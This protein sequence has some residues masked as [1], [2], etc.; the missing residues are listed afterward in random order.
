MNL[1]T[2]GQKRRV[3]PIVRA[4]IGSSSNRLPLRVIPHRHVAAKTGLRNRNSAASSS[5]MAL[6]AI[7]Q[8]PQR[9]RY[10]SKGERNV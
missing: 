1:S 9:E 4:L 5:R 3:L 8:P 2:H 6:V 10:V 7:A